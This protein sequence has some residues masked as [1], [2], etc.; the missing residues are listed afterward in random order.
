MVNLFHPHLERSV[1]NRAWAER[2]ANQPGITLRR[3]YALYPDGKIDVAA[4]QQALAEHERLVF[5]HPFYW[6]STPPLMKQWLDDVLTYGW[7]YGP[8]G[9][10]LA[11]KEW[12]SAISTG[13]PADSYQAGGYNRFSMSEFLKPLVQTASLLQTVFLP[14][15]IFHGAVAADNEAVR[16]SADALLDY[17]CNPLLDPQK[18]LAALQAKM[19]SEGV[20]LE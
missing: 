12:L 3:L 19:E 11:G 14:P 2:L 13:G 17:V 15:F 8:G 16:A 4:E 6:Y 18:K 20:K 10:A 5:Q 9:N 1:V 7:A